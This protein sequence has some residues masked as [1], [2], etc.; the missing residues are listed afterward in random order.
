MEELYNLLKTSASFDD[1]QFIKKL[2]E[3]SLGAYKSLIYFWLSGLG[4]GRGVIQVT[5]AAP[6][7]MEDAVTSVYQI[8]RA[9]LAGVP[10]GTAWLMVICAWKLSSALRH[11]DV[12]RMVRSA[13]PW[14]KFATVTLTVW[15]DLMKWPVSTSYP[16]PRCTSVFVDLGNIQFNAT[17]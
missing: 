4:M 15:M 9:R 14:S 5:T 17:P 10:W 7:T 16:A 2:V 12:V 3:N 13:F 1:N 8:L 11:H 6:K